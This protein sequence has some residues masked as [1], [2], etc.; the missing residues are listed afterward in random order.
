MEKEFAEKITLLQQESE[1][2]SKKISALEDANQESSEK[3]A[4][5]EAAS[6]R[7]KS[8][9]KKQK[10]KRNFEKK[11]EK[12]FDKKEHVSISDMSMEQLK[13]SYASSVSDEEKMKRV[14]ALLD[15]YPSMME[16]ILLPT[17]N[18]AIDFLKKKN[19]ISFSK[20]EEEK[21]DILFR[22]K[23]L[24]AEMNE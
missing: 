24:K 18:N 15:D 17:S 20:E 1:K 10:M 7:M 4:A 12:V 6:E 19:L 2:A 8:I 16:R 22:V 11:W 3:I 14:E 13:S 21:F 9:L 5:L 23:D